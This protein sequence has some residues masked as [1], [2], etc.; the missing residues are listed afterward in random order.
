MKHVTTADKSLLLGDEAAELLVSYAALLGRKSSADDVTLNAYGSDGDPV[1][2]TFLLNSGS[3]LVV[4]SS[5]SAVPEPDNHS[6]IDYM[7]DRM[8]LIESPPNVRPM[9]APLQVSEWDQ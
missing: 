4:E 6:G 9:D 7:R 2:V 1:E 3:V 5:E 8:D